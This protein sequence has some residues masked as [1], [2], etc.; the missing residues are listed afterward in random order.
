MKR[1][2]GQSQALLWFGAVFTALTSRCSRIGGT[3][4]YFIFSSKLYTT[5]LYFARICWYFF[6]NKIGTGRRNY[7]WFF[8]VDG[9]TSVCLLVWEPLF[10][11]PVGANGGTDTKT[12]SVKLRGFR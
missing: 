12:K 2:C 1:Q 9:A 7:A 8:S 11:L 3:L 5:I 10:C 6:H 4:Q